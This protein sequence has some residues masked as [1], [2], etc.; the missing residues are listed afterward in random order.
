[1]SIE[2][3]K[4]GKPLRFLGDLC[5]ECTAKK[6]VCSSYKTTNGCHNCDFAFCKCDYDEHPTHYCTKDMPERPLC[7]S[8]A[9][10]GECPEGYGKVF[11]EAY[12][13]WDAWKKNRE[14]EWMGICE[15]WKIEQEDKE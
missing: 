3:C 1:M 9:M 8:V 7:M 14:V 2:K 10:E 15:H 4:C 13:A 6:F 5:T 12:E 11:E